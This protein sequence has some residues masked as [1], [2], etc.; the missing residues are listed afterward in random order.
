[1]IRM[2]SCHLNSENLTMLASIRPYL[3]A[4]CLMLY[5]QVKAYA[6]IEESVVRLDTASGTLEGTLLV[7]EAKPSMPV[8]LLVAGSGPTDRNGN[9][10]GLHHNALLLLAQGLAQYGIASLRYDKRGVGQSISAATKEEDLRF[11]HYV[12]DVRDWITW[13]GRDKRFG[14][15]TL[16]GHSEGALLGMLAAQR[17]RVAQVVLIGSPGRAASDVLERQLAEQPVEIQTLAFPVL[18]QLRQGRRV[19]TVNPAIVALF[20]PSVQPYLLSWFKYDPA[21]EIA[22]L[23]VPVLVLQGTN[24]LQVSAED[25]ALLEIANPEATVIMMEGMNHILKLSV[26]D[27]AQNWNTYNQPELPVMPELVNLVAR[28]VIQSGRL[29]NQ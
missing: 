10:P 19:A 11:E 7:P 9:Q 2:K 5:A 23:K 4:I 26:P 15:M 22:K 1:M 20:R 12:T 14:K 29:G 3:I 25:A 27:R 8:V 16:L 13:L 21:N 17:S 24:D 6:A 18:K 28:F